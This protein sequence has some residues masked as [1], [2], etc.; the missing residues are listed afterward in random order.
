MG[1]FSV[2]ILPKADE[3]L[4]EYI[5]SGNKI[6]LKRIARIYEELA[7]HPEIGIG[8]PERLK[9]K[10]AG[11]WSR[12]IDKKNRM[13]YEITETEVIVHVHSMKGHYEDH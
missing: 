5:K 13:V 4:K 11:K 3:H 7:E 12:E 9:H 6:A 2:I 1:R 8:K 10:Y